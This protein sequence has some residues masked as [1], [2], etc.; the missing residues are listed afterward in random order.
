MEKSNST[1]VY[2]VMINISMLHIH[3]L[4]TGEAPQPYE[5][6]LIVHRDLC[7]HTSLEPA[8]VSTYVVCSSSMTL[9]VSCNL[10]ST[11]ILQTLSQSLN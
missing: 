6:L 5:R 11:L 4:G 7:H 3:F 8:S 10:L 1:E 9:T 2:E